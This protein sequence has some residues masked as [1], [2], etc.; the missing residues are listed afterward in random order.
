MKW[1]RF[2]SVA[3]YLSFGIIVLDTPNPHQYTHTIQYSLTS[4]VFSL[5]IKILFPATLPWG[6]LLFYNPVEVKEP[7]N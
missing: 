4:N 3:H 5:A 6:I 7:S 2:F 1:G